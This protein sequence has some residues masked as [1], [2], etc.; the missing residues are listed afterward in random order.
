MFEHASIISLSLSVP[1]I[2]V[3][4][5]E[6]FTSDECCC[7]LL[8]LVVSILAVSFVVFSQESPV[9]FFLSKS[10]LNFFYA[11]WYVRFHFISDVASLGP[12]SDISSSFSS[13]PLICL[14]EFLRFMHLLH[15]VEPVLKVCSY[16][17]S[18]KLLQMIILCFPCFQTFL[19]R[20]YTSICYVP[21][22]KWVS[23]SEEISMNFHRMDL[24]PSVR[25]PTCI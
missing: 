6:I 2:D 10:L 25:F 24:L 19:P 9:I 3:S 1:P 5:C 13:S 7:N 4:E 21:M 17:C 20:A 18:L 23:R 11:C 12:A 8:P 22:D 16:F 14:E 15:T